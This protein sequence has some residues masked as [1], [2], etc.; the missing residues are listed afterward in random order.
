MVFRMWTHKDLV[1]RHQA[2]K[3][4]LLAAREK[5]VARERGLPRQEGLAETLMILVIGHVISARI[6]ML[7]L[8]LHA[9]CAS[10]VG[11]RVLK[12]F[13]LDNIPFGTT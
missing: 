6:Q 7:S 3:M 4:Q 5:V 10:I 11:E 13:C 9:K 8:Q 12:W 2:Q 1:A